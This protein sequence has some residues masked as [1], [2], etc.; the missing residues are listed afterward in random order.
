MKNKVYDSVLLSRRLSACRLFLPRIS[1][2]THALEYKGEHLQKPKTPGF[3]MVTKMFHVS[4]LLMP[5]GEEVVVGGGNQRR[6]LSSH[7]LSI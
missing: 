4:L 3:S 7:L 2:K 6:D 1:I 5:K